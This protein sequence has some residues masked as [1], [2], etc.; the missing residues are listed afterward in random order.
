L[1]CTHMSEF[2]PPSLMPE[3]LVKTLGLQ[4][5]Q[6]VWQAMQDFTRER[7]RP[8]TSEIWIVEHPPVYTQGQAGKAE[9]LL[10]PGNI[11]VL[12]T[13][14]GGQVTYHGPGQAVIYFLLDLHEL[15]IG[16]RSLVT[17]L[18]NA[19][20][21]HLGS[22]GIIAAARRDAPGVYVD[23]RK[24]A[25]LGLRIRRGF[26]YHGLS[27]NVD[28]DLT[29]FQHINPCGYQGLEVTQMKNLGAIIGV[30]EAALD[31]VEQLAQQLHFT[32]T[33]DD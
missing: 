7:Q 10:S 24:I 11:P 27:L 21:S 2:I 9:H 28:M 8:S 16:V 14:R 20:I 18:E 4:P 29:P 30:R 31:V 32:V 1:S 6:Q 19:V 3:I 33:A 12:Q 22:H 13:D 15:K 5:Y 17:A 26:S 23:N 25:S